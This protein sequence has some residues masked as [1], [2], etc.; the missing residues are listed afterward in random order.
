MYFISDHHFHDIIVATDKGMILCTLLN[1]FDCSYLRK[2]KR[3]NFLRNLCSKIII[4]IILTLEEIS[5]SIK[6]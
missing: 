5:E 6:L 1:V 3:K 2:E 4:G